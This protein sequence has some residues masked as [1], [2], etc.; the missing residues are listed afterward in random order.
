MKVV[1]P[2]EGRIPR[3][4]TAVSSDPSE[5]GPAICEGT[6]MDVDRPEVSGDE[7]VGEVNVVGDATH[8]VVI[9]KKEIME[10]NLCSR[11]A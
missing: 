1:L 3:S 8:W 7:S 2:K 6:G 11:E 9:N 4:T 10:R 5:V